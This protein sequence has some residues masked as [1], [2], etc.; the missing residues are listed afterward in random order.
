MRLQLLESAEIV[1]ELDLRPVFERAFIA[2]LLTGRLN[3]IRWKTVPSPHLRQL[4]PGVFVGH[5][6]T[7]RRFRHQMVSDLKTGDDGVFPRLGL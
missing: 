5:P 1:E 2:R 3:D 6:E 4:S 7:V